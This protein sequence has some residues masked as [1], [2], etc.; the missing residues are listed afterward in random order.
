MLSSRRSGVNLSDLIDRP[1]N[2]TNATRQFNAVYSVFN[3]KLMNLS[4]SEFSELKT[5]M[6]SI[7]VVFG[8]HSLRLIQALTRFGTSNKKRASFPA[9]S[10]TGVV[11]YCSLA[12]R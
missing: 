5:Q 2:L 11:A 3:I 9:R 6:V 8:C 7:S 4:L 10:S 12:E 1:P